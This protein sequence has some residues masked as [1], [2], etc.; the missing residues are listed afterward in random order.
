MLPDAEIL[1]K[2]ELNRIAFASTSNRIE[3]ESVAQKA[4]TD[5]TEKSLFAG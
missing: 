2:I 3:S 4:R 1:F 5:S